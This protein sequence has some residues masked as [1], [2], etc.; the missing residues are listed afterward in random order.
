MEKQTSAKTLINNEFYD[1]LQDKWYT[2]WDHPIA[3]LRAENA[4][5]I[6]WIISEIN[7]R[8]GKSAKILDIG[9][10]GGFLTNALAKEGHQVV[11]IDISLTSLETAKQHD[12]TKQVQYLQADAYALPFTDESFDVVCA[13]DILEHVESPQK[14]IAQAAR[15][16][17]PSGLFFFHTFNRNLLSYFLVIKGVEWF[18]KNAPPH[19]HVYELFIKPKELEQI[20]LN[21]H[22]QVDKLIGFVPHIFSKAL[23]K[24]IT[25]RSI[26]KDFSFKFTKSL[27]TGYCGISIK[28]ICN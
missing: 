15:V 10:G 11:G 19:M 28:E 9:C 8:I 22:L 27:S 18:V 24:L 7:N 25:R 12:M 5:R 17:H 1:D 3:L 20:C 23:W 4:I 13:M 26:S 16:L 21:N 6:P 2:S 14:L